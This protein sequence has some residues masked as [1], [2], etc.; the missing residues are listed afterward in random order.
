MG[1]AELQA[2]RDYSGG[3]MSAIEL[4]RRLGDATYGEVLMRLGAAGLPLPCVSTPDREA[5]LARA[6]AW[7]F[8]HH[9]PHA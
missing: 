7:M 2:L 5:R 6:R 3:R 1:E 9:A 8:P 4:R